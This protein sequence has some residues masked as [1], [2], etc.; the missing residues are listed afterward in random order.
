MLLCKW[1][2]NCLLRDSWP[3]L[4]YCVMEKN[5]MAVPVKKKEDRMRKEGNNTSG[6]IMKS[7]DLVK[8]HALINNIL[9]VFY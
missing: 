4:W 8:H 6:R 7:G 1:S 9:R 3:F 2:R 5:P